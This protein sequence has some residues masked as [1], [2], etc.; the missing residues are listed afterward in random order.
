MSENDTFITTEEARRLLGVSTQ[1][2]RLWDKTGKIHTIR[3]PSNR[4]KYSQSDIYNIIGWNQT[5]TKK[6]QVIYARVSS[7]KQMDDL[8]RQKNLL[9]SNFIDYELVTDCGSGINWKRQGLKTIL[10][11]A[12]SGALEKVVVTHRDR[13]CRFAFELLQFIFERCKVELVVLNE[14]TSSPTTEQELA[15]DILSIIQVYACRK[16]GKRRYKSKKIETISNIETE[17]TIER[18]DGNY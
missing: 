7:K 11:W 5:I 6:K 2:L 13:L 10:E 3:T 1:T 16:M 4:R 8:E 18:M 17:K 12:M 14:E 9:R 15:D